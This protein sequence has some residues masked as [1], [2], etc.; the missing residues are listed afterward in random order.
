[1]SEVQGGPQNEP[2][3]RPPSLDPRETLACGTLARTPH[4]PHLMCPLCRLAPPE[5]AR[6]GASPLLSQT[7]LS[8]T[9]WPPEASLVPTGSDAQW[10]GVHRYGHEL[11]QGQLVTEPGAAG[12]SGASAQGAWPR[13]GAVPCAAAVLHIG[14][15]MAQAGGSALYRCGVA[16]GTD[17]S[18]M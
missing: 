6:P 10:Q 2:R 11:E 12:W 15:G 7:P 4:A 14:G 3:E 17:R 18:S 1:M 5:F 13:R 8:C 9:I 16:A